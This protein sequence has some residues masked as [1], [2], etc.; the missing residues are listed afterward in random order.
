L[1]Q[2]NKVLFI[3]I[4]KKI[5]MIE[6]QSVTAFAPATV[7]NISCG[8]D[9]MGF[10]LEGA[11]D[12]VTVSITDKP[13]ED[14]IKLAGRYGGL[15]PA[16]K[17]RNTAGVAAYSLLRAV[18]MEKI[19]VEITLEKNLPVGSGMGSSAASSAAAVFALNRLLGNPFS[20]TELIPFA[21]EGERAACGTAHADNVAPSLLGKFVLIRSYDPLDIISLKMPAGLFCVLIHPH[22]EV[23]T[24]DARRVL[25]KDF[26]LSIVTRQ[27]ANTAALT[28]GLLTEDYDLIARSMTDLLAEPR[29]TMLIPGFEKAKKSAI[30]SGAVGCGISG[31][32]PSMFAFCRSIADAEKIAAAIQEA[33]LL[34]AGLESDR[35]ISSLNAP[36]ARIIEER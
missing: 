31:S 24:S 16:D 6:K 33:F 10:A 32:G 15:I 29:R 4:L 14:K 17:D 30:D 8:F 3:D 1:Y 23:K 36:G 22:V 19:S 11:G 5:W 12:N 21:M 27:S 34:H 13:V 26:P 2:Y 28:A 35:I 25:R 7:A 20:T 18:G 9:I